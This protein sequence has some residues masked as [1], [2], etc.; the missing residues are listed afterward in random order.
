[1]LLPAVHRDRSVWGETADEFDPDRFLPENSRGRPTQTYKPFGTG[2]RSCIGRQFALHE[3][4]LVLARMLHRYELTY[5]P[6]YELSITERLTLMPEGFELGLRLRTPSVGGA[7]DDENGQ[8]EPSRTCPASSSD[9]P[10]LNATSQGCPSGS[11]KY[12]E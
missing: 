5:D 12:P 7:G 2:E 8:S 6:S 3:A 9:Q 10:G 11:A 1:M 4:I